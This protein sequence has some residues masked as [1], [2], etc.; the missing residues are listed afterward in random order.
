V[1]LYLGDAVTEPGLGA[2]LITVVGN[3]H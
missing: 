3:R 1:A 2:A